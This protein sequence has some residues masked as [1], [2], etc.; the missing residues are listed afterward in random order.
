MS[1]AMPLE[2]RAGG[3]RLWALSLEAFRLARGGGPV[4]ESPDDLEVG[5]ITIPS[6]LA[7]GRL[8][9]I[10]YLPPDENELSRIPHVTIKALLANPS[11]AETFRGKVV[12]V[13]ATSQSA[14]RDR[15]MTPYTTL[16]PMPGVEIHA[17]AYETLAT[18][19]FLTDASPSLVLLLSIAL[20]AGAAA[21]FW[22]FTG[23]PAYSLAAALLG[24]AHL[25]PH[26]FFMAGIVFSHVAPMLAAWFAVVVAAAWQYFSTRLA[27]ATAEGERARY[28]QAIQF[29]THEMRTPLTAIQ[30][31]SELMGRY[32]LTE[33]KQKQLAAQINSESKR[34]ARM[35]Q[36][37]LDVERLGAGQMQLKQDPIPIPALLTVCVD[38]VKPLA[39]RKNIALDLP[40]PLDVT[41]QGDRELLEYAVYNL[42]TNAIKYSQPD[43]KVE[44][45][46]ANG[47]GRLRI[48]VRDQGMGM[49]AAELKKLF[50]KFYRT[51]RAEQSG[52]VGTGIGLS[53]VQQIVTL[54]GGRIE[55]TS[56]PGEGSCFTISLPTN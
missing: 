6:S 48:A 21:I 34:L 49:S 45:T 54:H 56:Q 44:V 14:V 3:L 24:V 7:G 38:R 13:G 8:M 12:F 52:E 43:T 36:T 5:G 51:A 41:L 26:I 4:T 30:G 46:T 31:S 37:F 39:E 35:I 25:I 20:V 18:G 40:T 42:L 19:Q 50:T 32:K 17:H 28:Q 29:V 23:L 53:I 55:V 11:L 15:L 33:E 1:R 27:L 9:R 2:K 16:Q 47:Q 10:R 22:R